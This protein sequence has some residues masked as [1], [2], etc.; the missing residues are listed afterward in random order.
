MY[1]VMTSADHLV[2][3]VMT[4]ADHLV[5]ARTSVWCNDIS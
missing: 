2:Y 4:S 5:R 3:G 1:G